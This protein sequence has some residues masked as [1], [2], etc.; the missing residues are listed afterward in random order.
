MGLYVG[1]L[2]P[3]FPTCFGCGPEAG[4]GAGLRVAAHREGDD[5]VATHSFGEQ[6]SGAPGIAHGGLVAALVD[7]L[8]GYVVWLRHEPAV[9][10]TLE[11]DYRQ[12]VL[13]GVSYDLRARIDRV[14]G[15]KVFASC[16]GRIAGGAPTFRGAG[17]FV[18]VEPTHF[19]IGGAA[20]ARPTV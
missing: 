11:L 1:A 8:L 19:S 10:R 13:V 17:L 18:K 20:A 9:T 15:R 16:E 2:P 12:P 6:H 5:I 14:D 4:G 7:E 3:H